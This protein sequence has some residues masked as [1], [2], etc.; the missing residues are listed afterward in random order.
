MRAEI[1]AIMDT[2]P[3]TRTPLEVNTLYL[4]MYELYSTDNEYHITTENMSERERSIAEF[5]VDTYTFDMMFV[6]FPLDAYSPFL[7]QVYEGLLTYRISIFPHF[8]EIVRQRRGWF[9]LD[10]SLISNVIAVEMFVLQHLVTVHDVD[11]MPDREEELTFWRDE[12][13]KRWAWASN[14]QKEYLLED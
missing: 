5:F 2:A 1:F 14:L 13:T 10:R 11:F 4:R 9:N 12:W 8:L 6:N 3:A 7:K